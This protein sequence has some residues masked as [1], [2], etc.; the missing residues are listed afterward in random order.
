[1]KTKTQQPERVSR[2][3]QWVIVIALLACYAYFFPRWADPNQ[4]SRLDMI[5]A[6]VDDGTF[7]ID[8]YVSNTVDYAKVGE[9]YYSDKPPGSAFL[10]IPVYAGLKLVM[11]TPLVDRLVERLSSNAAFQAT[12]K[13]DGSGVYTDKVRFALAQVALTLVIPVAASVILGLLL[14][15]I[16]VDF[17][18]SPGLSLLVVLTYGLLTPAFAYAGAYYSHQLSAA[19]LVGAFALVKSDKVTRPGRLLLAGFLMGFAVLSEY[20][21]ILVAVILFLYTLY[22]LVRL[23]VWKRAGWAALSAAAVGGALMAYNQAVFGGPFQLGYEYSEL[24]KPQHQTG[25]LSLTLPHPDAIWGITF[26]PFR[27]LFYLSPIL[28]LCIPGFV[29]WWQSRRNRAE[30]WVSLSTVLCMFLFNTSSVMWWGGFAVGPRYFLPAIPFIALAVAF[31]AQ[32]WGNRIWFKAAWV[33]LSIWSAVV[34]WG[35]SLA[36]QAFPSDLIQNPFLEYALPN[37]QAGNIARNFGTI[38]GLKGAASLVPLAGLLIFVVS[39]WLAFRTRTEPR[40][41][42]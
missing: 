15:R 10:G 25:F 31:A 41:V 17:H 21:V 16:L 20:S 5:V 27:G 26:S 33:V 19:F 36:G 9:H 2:V 32:A 39:I 12:L 14:Y 37:W 18:I 28:L 24:W 22:R 42:D 30:F 35:I 6:V 29:F 4:N 38:A 40:Q 34:T 7:M 23:G 1:M 3:N 8:R 11:D 13:A